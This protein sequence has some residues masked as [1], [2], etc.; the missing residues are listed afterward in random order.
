MSAIETI[1][2]R[3]VLPVRADADAEAKEHKYCLGQFS[4]GRDVRFT[5]R[6]NVKIDE[7]QT[8]VDVTRIYTGFLIN[9]ARHARQIYRLMLSR[10]PITL[11]CEHF[12]CQIVLLSPSRFASVEPGHNVART[13]T[14][15]WS[16]ADSR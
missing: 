7:I 8:E 16:A 14:S 15:L 2:M 12:E 1:F 4:N 11:R 9:H 10:T 5:A 13:R 3:E 6:F